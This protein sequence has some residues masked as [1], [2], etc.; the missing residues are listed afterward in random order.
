MR[1]QEGAAR[2]RGPEG[3]PGT[4]GGNG[5][6]LRVRRGL[7]GGDRRGCVCTLTERLG[8]ELTDGSQAGLRGAV[9]RCSG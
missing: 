8:P 9:Q 1:E 4:R 2:A 3:L 5:A 7:E 6:Q